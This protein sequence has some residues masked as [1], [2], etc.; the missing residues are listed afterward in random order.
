MILFDYDKAIHLMECWD[1]DL[2]LP[3]TLLNA[4]YLADHWKHD[5]YTSIGSYTTFDKDEPYQLFVGLPR[6]RQI[7]PFITCRRAS[8]EGDM[9]NW[10]MWIDDRR[11]WGLNELPRSVNSPLPPLAPVMYADP[12]EAVAS[13]VRERGLREANI[14]VERRYLGVEG[15]EKL[16]RLLPDVQFRDA[17]ELL[18]ELRVVKSEEEVRRMRIAAHATQQALRITL[19]KLQVGMTGLDLESVVGAEHYRAGVRHEWIHTQI[20]AL[21]IDVVGPNPREIGIGDIVRIDTGCSYRHY[22]S[23]FGLMIAVGEPNKELLRIY[24]AM[25]T[26]MDA[27][28]EALQPGVS[29]PKLFDIGNRI[30]EREHYESYLMYLGHGI[31]RNGHEEPVLAPDSTRILAENMTLAVELVTVRPDLGLIALEDIVVITPEGYEDLSTI[32]RELHVIEA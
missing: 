14:G 9:Y 26:A 18:L 19:E 16:K 15:Y 13:A 31:G 17:S 5:L 29:A 30:F 27:V 21:G 2:L 11:I 3:H 28:L 7:E 24:G 22:R 10:G 12:Y 23:D 25:R 32:G 4:G 6:D 8:E 20:G 1:I